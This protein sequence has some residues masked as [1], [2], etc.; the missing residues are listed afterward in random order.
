MYYFENV[1]I[2]NPNNIYIICI[3]DFISNKWGQVSSCYLELNSTQ[4]EEKTIVPN[5]S[6]YV[7]I[8]NIYMSIK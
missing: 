6:T 4:F 5:P 8:S 1:I 2:M 3:K 7:Y